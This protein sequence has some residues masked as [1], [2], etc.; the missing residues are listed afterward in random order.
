[1][2]ALLQERIFTVRKTLE[3]LMRGLGNQDSPHHMPGLMGNVS[4]KKNIKSFF[5]VVLKMQLAR[6]QNTMSRTDAEIG[7]KSHSKKANNYS[8]LTIAQLATHS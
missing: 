8:K 4:K 2:V 1:L 3:D 5:A 6:T 7:S